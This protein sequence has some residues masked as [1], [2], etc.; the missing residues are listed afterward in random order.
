MAL[1]QIS[2]PGQSPAPHEQ[3][4]AVGIDLGTTNSLVATVRS[5]I[6]ETLPDEQGRHL[7]PSI[8][9]YT[10][11]KD[12]Q[13]GEEADAAATQDPLNTIASIKRLMGRGVDDLARAGDRLPYEF[14][15]SNSKMP[16]IRTVRGD[17]S[18]VEISAEILKHLKHRAEQTLGGEL[19]GAVITVPA[20]FD[21]SQRQAT[22]DAARLAGLKVLRLI[23]EPTAAAVAYG[24][25]RESE[26]IHVIYDLGGGTFDVSILR[27]TQ[28]VFEVMST[29][30]DTALGGDDLDIRIAEWIMEQAGI[31][32]DADHQ[33]MRRLLRDARQAKEKLTEQDAVLLHIETTDGTA[34]DGELTRDEFNRIIEPVI[35]KTLLPCKRALRDA[36]ISAGEIEDV[37]MVGGTTRIGRVREIV[38]E[39][40]NC[41]P[42]VDIDPDRVVAI[43][44]AIQA[45]V[46]VGNKRDEDMLLLDVIPLSL[47]IET[48]GGLVERII[49]RNTTIP[50][51][52]AQDFTT[53]KDGQTAMSIHV[54]QGERELVTDNRSLAQFE[55][56]GIPPMAAGSARIRVTFQVDADG[57]LE[58]VARE[59]ATGIQSSVQVRPS[60][61]LSDNEIETMLRDSLDHIKDDVEAR[62]LREQV[63]EADR[64]LEAVTSAMESDADLIDDS[65]HDAI[66]SAMEELKTARNGNDYRVIKRAI[67]ELDTATA[68]FAARRMDK[69]IRN[70]LKGH[71]LEEIG[72][73][74]R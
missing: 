2:E 57:L 28:G 21:D 59:Q 14:V 13:V 65:E 48:M 66:L 17:V 6:A 16:K 58:V 63:V 41:E 70:A 53:C 29:A 4:L 61:G 62:K 25:D 23:N 24:L 35:R 67:G 8:V 10:R 19:S 20:Y 47:G 73:Q 46:L 18:P 40:F 74:S 7:L 31:D 69:T 39:F 50:A 37:V 11:D 72:D 30:G 64:L 68:D 43:G 12:P 9:R 42:L 60:Y 45:D 22:K 5:G 32:D 15:E 71:T 27:L 26:G 38:G 52:K 34:W 3:R 36:G 44:A 1:L 33:E 56:R 49:P 54:V 51:A 55:L